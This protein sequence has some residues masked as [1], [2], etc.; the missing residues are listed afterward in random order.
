MVLRS[1]DTIL[2]GTKKRKCS[3]TIGDFRLLRRVG[4]RVG[5]CGLRITDC[6]LQIADCSA[7]AD[8]GLRIGRLGID[9]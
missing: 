3:G 4:L 6:G 9:E 1:E 7:V 5:D 8:C 2:N